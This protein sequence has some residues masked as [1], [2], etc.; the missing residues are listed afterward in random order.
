MDI[1]VEI[2]L[3]AKTKFWKQTDNISCFLKNHFTASICV[4]NGC[5]CQAQISWKQDGW[6]VHFLINFLNYLWLL[7]W[8]HMWTNYHANI[9]ITKNKNWP[10]NSLEVVHDVILVVTSTNFR[11]PLPVKICLLTKKCWTSIFGDITFILCSIMYI[12]HF[13]SSHIYVFQKLIFFPLRPYL[14]K[15]F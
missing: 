14:G 6:K 10:F 7:V 9:F 13:A 11:Y 5:K 15:G 3:L 2:F 1:Q 12:L 8:P 4:A